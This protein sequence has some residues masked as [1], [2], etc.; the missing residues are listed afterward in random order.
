M[1]NHFHILIRVVTRR[2]AQLTNEELLVRLWHFYNNPKDVLVRAELQ[3]GLS[4]KEAQQQAA[5][6]R[7]LLARMEDLSA[8]V[9]LLKQRFSIWYNRTHGR[10]GTHGCERFKSLLVEG[11][12][13]ALRLVTAY[14]L[15]SAESCAGGALPGSQGLSFQ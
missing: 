4:S 12:P 7:R 3:A 14:S 5:T 1:S 8:F 10:V 11:T 6:R 15:H 13:H 9:K 2:S